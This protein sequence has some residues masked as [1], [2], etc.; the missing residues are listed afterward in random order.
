MSGV[1]LHDPFFKPVVTD[2]WITLGSRNKL[3]KQHWHIIVFKVIVVSLIATVVYLYIQ[4]IQRIITV[5]LELYDKYTTHVTDD[6]SDV[7]RRRAVSG[8]GCH[9]ASE[10]YFDHWWKNKLL[11]FC[12]CFHLLWPVNAQKGGVSRENT[13]HV[14]FFQWLTVFTSPNRPWML[15]G[16]HNLGSSMDMGQEMFMPFMYIDICKYISVS[17]FCARGVCKT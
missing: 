15:F 9:T 12:G 3:W 17:L 5:H 4:W 1:V 6:T 16:K 14:T 11:S 10:H 8:C 2:G 7:C 13:A